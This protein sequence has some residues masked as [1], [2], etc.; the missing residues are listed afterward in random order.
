MRPGPPGRNAAHRAFGRPDMEHGLIRRL[1]AWLGCLGARRWAA[2]VHPQRLPARSPRAPV[3]PLDA[4]PRLGVRGAGAERA[5]GDEHSSKL[6]AVVEMLNAGGWSG[7][8]FTRRGN[9]IG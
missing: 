8:R 3:R 4:N 7:A 1:A 5:G 6:T 2:P 9:R